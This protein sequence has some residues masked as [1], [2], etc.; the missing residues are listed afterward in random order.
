MDFT[1]NELSLA[2]LS[3]KDE[4][5][6]VFMQL[7]DVAA[8]LESIGF[9]TMKIWDKSVFYTHPFHANTTLIDWLKQIHFSTNEEK[10]RSQKLKSII[11]KKDSDWTV[12]E[13]TLIIECPIIGIQLQSNQSISVGLKIA[14]LYNTI[15]VSF[16]SATQWNK[17]S[18]DLIHIEE[19][20]IGE[21]LEQSVSIKH[22]SALSHIDEQK[23]W[24]DYLIAHKLI[25][26]DWNPSENYFPLLD[27]SNTL[28]E[29][30]NWETFRQK[31]DGAKSSQERLAVII[32]IGKKVA[33]RNSYT[34]DTRVSTLN[35]SES[36]K[37]IIFGA[38]KGKK[39][40]YLSIDLEKGG[41]EVCNYLGEHIGE[42][43]F[44]GSPVSEKK[45]GHDIK[46]KS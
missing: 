18:L 10:V 44:D 41:F 37:R 27:F 3:S 15:A 24:L 35:T 29:N 8:S 42:Y 21:T 43:F 34:H 30:G 31:R 46:V 6:K 20:E 23:E 7:S 9:K 12:E 28:I 17:S 11:Q 33:E 39:K 25:G 13:K 26:I 38:G 22:A 14:C 45:L 2:T 1:L 40:I 36:I 32:E 4:A 16:N 19:N 5:I